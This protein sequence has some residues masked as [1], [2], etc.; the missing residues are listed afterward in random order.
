MNFE[1]IPSKKFKKEAKRFI[2]KY[3]SFK[4]ELHELAEIPSQNPETGTPLGNNIYKNRLAIK[5]KGKGKSGGSRVITH[6]VNEH[7]EVYL[8]TIYAKSEF[9]Q[10]DDKSVQR[11]IDSLDS[12]V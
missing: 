1:V 12:E 4:I 3:A 11:I 6:V 2:K 10:I 7:R 9:D 5:A 8:L